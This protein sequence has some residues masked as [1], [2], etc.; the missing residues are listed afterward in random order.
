MLYRPELA[1]DAS[2][3]TIATMTLTLKLAI[4]RLTVSKHKKFA[5]V[6]RLLVTVHRA[7]ITICRRMRTFAGVDGKAWRPVLA[8]V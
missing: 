6:A 8:R 1:Q 5:E 2:S 7:F 4:V 3:G